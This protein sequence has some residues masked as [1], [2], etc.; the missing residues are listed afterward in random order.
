[1]KR[2]IELACSLARPASGDAGQPCAVQLQPQLPQQQ[3]PAASAVQSYSLSLDGDWTPCSTPSPWAS[4]V[5][6]PT[7]GEP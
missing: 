3:K 6:G 4:P 1:M 2:R 7:L 5:L